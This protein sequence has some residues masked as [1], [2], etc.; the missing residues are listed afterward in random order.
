MIAQYARA[1]GGAAEGWAAYKAGVDEMGDEVLEYMRTNAAKIHKTPDNA[2]GQP[3]A[4]A[5]AR[6]LPAE[7]LHRQRV[8]EREQLS[9]IARLRAEAK[10]EAKPDASPS[11]APAAD[12]AAPAPDAQAAD[13]PAA[14]APGKGKPDE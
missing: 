8:W 11:A 9:K 5:A 14:G 3:V 1:E 12:D 10:P 2:Q 7:E 4:A 13:E 6:A